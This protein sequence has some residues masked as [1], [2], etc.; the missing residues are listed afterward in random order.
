MEGREVGCC[1]WQRVVFWNLL[2]L[3]RR[4]ERLSINGGVDNNV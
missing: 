1:K 4:G 2:Q 3:E